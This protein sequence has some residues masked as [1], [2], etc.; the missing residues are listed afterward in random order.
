MTVTVH[1]GGS[2]VLVFNVSGSAAD[3]YASDFSGA[4]GSN[5]PAVSTLS[6]G[7][8]ESTIAG[9][10]NIVYSGGTTSDYTLSSPDQYTYISVGD[11]TTINGSSGGDTLFGG[12]DLTYV[13]ASGGHNNRVVFTTGTNKFVGATNDSGDTIAGGSGYD[14]IMTGGGA[15]T[16]FSGTGH[17]LI[18]TND[19]VAGDVVVMGAGNTTVDANG[20]SDTVFASATGTI[21][22]GSGTLNFTTAP[23]TSPLE[24]TIVGGSGTTNAFGSAGTDLT[25]AGGGTVNYVA[26]AG[27]ET[28]NG[29]NSGGFNFVGDTNPGD[30]VNDTV[31]GGAGFDYFATGAGTEYFQ[32]GS[33]VDSFSIASI[34]GGANITIADFGGADSVSF[35][36]GADSVG[37]SDGTN[38]TVTLSDG[39]HVEFLGITSLSGHI[40]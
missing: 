22:G 40:T 19:T 38:Y 28:L 26:G 4:V 18:E 15:S 29:F 37:V 7:G 12:A 33:G 36:T 34:V 35:F 16:V 20:I 27:N 39:T 23:S 1:G 6:S 5:P 11:P 3:N 31:I 8:T 14:T 24:V 30:S 25:L 2:T 21:F 17:T 9:A 10:L 13:E 32:A